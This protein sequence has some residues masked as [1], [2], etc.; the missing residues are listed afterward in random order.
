MSLPSRAEYDQRRSPSGSIRVFKNLLKRVIGFF[1]V[2][3]SESFCASCGSERTIHPVTPQSRYDEGDLQILS[4]CIFIL[5][6]SSCGG[7]FP[8]P[9]CP[10][11]GILECDSPF[12]ELTSYLVSLREVF[13][14]SG[15]VPL[16]DQS[17]QFP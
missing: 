4:Y 3:D 9:D 7:R 2:R 11:R 5:N 17:Q 6:S 14:S 13:R 10:P 8:S 15:L 1:G 12:R 16:F